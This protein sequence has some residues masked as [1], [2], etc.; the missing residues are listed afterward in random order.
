MRRNDLWDLLLAA[1]LVGASVTFVYT[2]I[3]EDTK[4]S[5]TEIQ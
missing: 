5:I 2:L 4:T 1:A 3:M